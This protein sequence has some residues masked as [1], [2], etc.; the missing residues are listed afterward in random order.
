MWLYGWGGGKTNGATQLELR[1]H[2][3]MVDMGGGGVLVAEKEK[4]TMSEEGKRL[5]GGFAL[6]VVEEN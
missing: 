6:P 2:G 4:K 1:G 5:V 3:I